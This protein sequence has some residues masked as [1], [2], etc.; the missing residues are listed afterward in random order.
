MQ[1]PV[2]VTF[3]GIDP[4][5]ALNEYVRR[6]AAKLDTF[7]DRLIGCH[8]N[9]EAPHRHHRH[10]NHYLVRIDL[11]VPG[12]KLVVRRT[13]EES[14][15][16]EDMY[17]RID[18]VF[19]EA[20]RVLQEYARKRRGDVKTHEGRRHGSV[21]K[22]FKQEGYG[23]LESDDGEEFYF[24]RNSVLHAAFGRLDVGS[25]VRFTDE[26]GERGPQASTVLADKG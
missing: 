9:L 1:N 15:S 19:D 22:L 24:H 14:P 2:Q 5:P 8:V 20:G 17:A 6:R 16:P 18:I 21:T 11:T 10:G 25:R 26:V 12:A 23:F 4:A 3:R 13:P 7:F